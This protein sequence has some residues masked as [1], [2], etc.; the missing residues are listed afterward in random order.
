MITAIR[1]LVT[2]FLGAFNNNPDGWSGRKLAAFGGSLIGAWVT[3]QFA[4]KSNAVELVMT[5]LTFALL[6]LGIITLQQVI[7]LRAGK[8]K[9]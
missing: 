7:D 9:P 3:F 8:P 5:W 4:D 6:C 2:S 1:W